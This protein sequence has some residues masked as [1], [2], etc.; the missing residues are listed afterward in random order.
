MNQRRGMGSVAIMAIVAMLAGCGS[1]TEKTAETGTSTV[2][3]SATPCREEPKAGMTTLD[4]D[5]DGQVYPTEVYRPADAGS[6]PVPAVIDLHG[7][8]SNGPAQAAL[9]GFRRLA[10]SEGFVVAEPSG[11]VG[12]LGVTGWEIAAL[13]E[14]RRNDIGAMTRLIESLV[15]EHC[16]DPERVFVAGYSNGGFLAAEL[17]CSPGVEV[18]AVAAIAGFHA[19]PECERN[20]P[21]LVM[22]GTADPIVPLGPN[23]TS[24]IVDDTTP[25]PVKELL[26][27]S[28]EGE[29]AASAAD[30]GCE[31][32][33]TSSKLAPTITKLN[34]EGC[35]DAAAHE[36]M[37]IDGGG[38]TWPGA[39][40]TADADFVG[41]TT[42]ELDATSTAWKFFVAHTGRS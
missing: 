9:S 21:T 37:L 11:P 32:A 26:S 42:S 22:H 25:E 1:E 16:V 38:H 24:L 30:A 23:G 12:P 15:D 8:D 28:I 3:V 19:P 6:A 2:P 7:L 31:S 41:P 40:P 34:Y 20:V 14:A 13:D 10:D 36:L 29:V 5:A 18:A 33:P 27:S 39:A 4:V 35:S 17:G